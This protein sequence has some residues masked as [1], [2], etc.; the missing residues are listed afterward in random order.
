MKKK[1]LLIL[2]LI[3][4]PLVSIWLCSF[5]D[6][7]FN[8]KDKAGQKN[9]IAMYAD[10]FTETSHSLHG[11]HKEVKYTVNCEWK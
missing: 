11:H 10:H 2:G 9:I 6:Q 4:I 3:L 1:V 7:V 5:G 8:K